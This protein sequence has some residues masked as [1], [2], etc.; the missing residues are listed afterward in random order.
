MFTITSETSF[1]KCKCAT[2]W[3][4]FAK[5]VPYII[6]AKMQ[7]LTDK[8]LYQLCKKYGENALHWRRKFTGLLPEVNRRRLY[9]K[10]GFTSI[11]EFAKKL[12]GLS[13]EQVRR[14]LNLEERFK[15]KPQLHRALIHGKVSVNKLA[16]VV[17]VATPESETFWAEKAIQLPNRALETLIRDIKIEDKDGLNKTKIVQK[18]VHVHRSEE[19]KLAPDVTEELLVMQHKGI[20]VNQLL[21]EF[22]EKRK[23]EI[24]QEKEAL[25]VMPAKSRYI[26]VKIRRHLEKE[27]GGLCSIKSCR[28]PAQVIHHTQRF[29]LSGNHNPK[30]LAPLCCEHHTIAHAIDAKVQVKRNLCR[31]EDE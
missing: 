28:R 7:Y 4:V 3:F 20:D 17:S 11:F 25:S 6:H 18:S 24:A 21:R 13:E 31:V 27:H 5:I 1:R 19:L 15:D 8:E 12:C 2:F 26:P 30:Y 29:A 10:K 14:V 22:L 23:L 9:E 16:R